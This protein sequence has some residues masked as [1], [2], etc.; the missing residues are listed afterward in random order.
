MDAVLGGQDV[1]WNHA[2]RRRKIALLPTAGAYDGRRDNC[3]VT[4]HFTDEGSGSGAQQRPVSRSLYQ[5]F[6]DKETQISK[7]LALAER[8]DIKSFTWRRNGWRYA[9]RH[10]AENLPIS[11]ITVDGAHCISQWGQDFRPEVT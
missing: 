6:T 4:A 5:Q 7:A 10:L 3:R 1:L 9:F 11:M 2:D 8:E